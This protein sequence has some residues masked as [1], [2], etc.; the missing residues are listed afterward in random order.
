MHD[1]TW[2]VVVARLSRGSIRKSFSTSEVGVKFAYILFFS[3]F[4]VWN[5]TGYA[6][7]ELVIRSSRGSIGNSLSTCEVGVKSA[8]ILSFS[9]LIVWD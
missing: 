6:V 2:Y 3:D 1:Y 9:D 5:Y 4:I 7:V 8:Y